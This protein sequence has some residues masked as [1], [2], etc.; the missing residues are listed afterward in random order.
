MMDVILPKFANI[1]ICR[2]IRHFS[3]IVTGTLKHNQDYICYQLNFN[4]ITTSEW[5]G[6]HEFLEK[7][8]NE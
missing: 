2:E 3:Y 5:K 6:M 4:S 7:H 1:D 8:S